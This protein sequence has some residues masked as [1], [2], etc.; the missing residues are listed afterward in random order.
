MIRLS[1]F[2]LL[3]ILS[4]SIHAQATITF[5]TG[6]HIYYMEHP[7]DPSVH[8]QINRER[9][10]GGLNLMVREL[11]RYG[12]PECVMY[13]D[14]EVASITLQQYPSGDPRV[15][16]MADPLRPGVIAYNSDTATQPIYFNK[17]VSFCDGRYLVIQTPHLARATSFKISTNNRVFVFVTNP[18][19]V[20]EL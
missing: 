3:L 4:A 9:N 12:V 17:R 5:R 20:K 10:P 6:D 11:T 2:I 7:W 1:P 14:S 16:A 8:H 18:G 19:I 15:V 13:F